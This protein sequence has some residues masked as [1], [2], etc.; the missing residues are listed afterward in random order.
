M[1][2][3]ATISVVVPVY[4]TEAYLGDCLESIACQ[5]Y[6]NLEV[7]IIDD[8]STDG[9]PSIC[10]QFVKR[11]GRFRY[12]R[13]E[14]AGQ[15]AARNRGMGEA[16]GKYL[17]FIDSD[18]WWDEDILETLHDSLVSNNAQFVMCQVR[19]EG[20]PNVI[21]PDLTDI[22]I[23][24][25]EELVS[26]VL[27]S[28]K[29]FSASVNHALFVAEI[30]KD[31]SMIEGH[32]FEDLDYLVRLG[33]SLHRA[34]SLPCRK[35]HYRYREGNSSSRKLRLRFEDMN[36]VYHS[37]QEHLRAA[38]GWHLDELDQRYISGVVGH[39][40]DDA[41]ERDRD[42]FTELRNEVLAKQ[43][44]PEM[45]TKSVRLRYGAMKCGRVAYRVM[46]SLYQVFRGCRSA[47]RLP[48]RA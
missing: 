29:G 3:E 47:L 25:G 13:Q 22:C 1:D 14:N 17:A 39:L 46:S 36:A 42:L 37:M 15:S 32:I 8:G 12:I 27:L 5:T 6:Q 40:A 26:N 30:T 20:F 43:W 28:R 11:D 45:Q 18:D 33:G 10:R 19:H 48:Y 21:D 34:V 35:Y 31:I 24:N 9:S 4:N 41:A 7:I 38:G 16:S 44:L 23:C 2:D